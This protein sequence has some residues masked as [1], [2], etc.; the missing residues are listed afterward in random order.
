MTVEKNKNMTV[1]KYHI[2]APLRT[3]Y[4]KQVKSISSLRPGC[5]IAS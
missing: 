4:K 1:E 3:Y 2:T 5:C